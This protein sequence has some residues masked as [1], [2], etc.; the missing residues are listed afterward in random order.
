MGFNKWHVPD[1]PQELRD[2]V[3]EIGSNEFY[4]IYIKKTD[5]FI[6]SSKTM[7]YLE[8]FAKQYHETDQ[9]FHYV[10]EELENLSEN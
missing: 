8:Q 1:D 5:S 3:K 4:R 9:E 10:S 6:G 7:R 2:R